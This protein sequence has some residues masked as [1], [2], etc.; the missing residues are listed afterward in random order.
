MKLLFYTPVERLLLTIHDP[1]TVALNKFLW[2]R[3]WEVYSRLDDKGSRLTSK[4][5]RLAVHVSGLLQI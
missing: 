2:N 5:A 4:E 3:A 1:A